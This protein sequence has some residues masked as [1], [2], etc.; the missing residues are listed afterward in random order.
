MEDSRAIEGHRE[1]EGCRGEED[2]RD[3][4]YRGWGGGVRGVV[5]QRDKEWKI[6][7]GL[8]GIVA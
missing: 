7:K 3:E 8:K 2:H 4:G 6:C 5:G 1:V